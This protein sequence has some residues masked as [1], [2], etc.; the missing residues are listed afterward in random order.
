M[1]SGSGVDSSSAP[2][3]A[4]VLAQNSQM[5]TVTIQTVEPGVLA[6]FHTASTQL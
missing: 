5:L 4:D 3:I 1:L 2:E 6:C